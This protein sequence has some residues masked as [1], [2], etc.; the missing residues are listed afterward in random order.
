MIEETQKFSA[1][2]TAG[3]SSEEMGLQAKIEISKA[4][5]LLVDQHGRDADIVAARRADALLCEGNTTEGAR[6]LAIFRRIAMSYLRRAPQ[7]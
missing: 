5:Q 7:N 1:N 3:L 2:G 6:W 4:A